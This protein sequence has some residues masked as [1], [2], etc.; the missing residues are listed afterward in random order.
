[1]DLRLYQNGC[2]VG[3]IR[4]SLLDLK[5]ILGLRIYAFG[6]QLLED[7]YKF[8]SVTNTIYFL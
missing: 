2:K 6:I 4:I 8:F 5:I 1:M 7:V 3:E